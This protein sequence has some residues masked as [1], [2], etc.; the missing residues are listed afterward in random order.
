MERTARSLSWVALAAALIGLL[1][2]LVPTLDRIELEPG[3]PTAPAPGTARVATP[4]LGIAPTGSQALL[5]MLRIL[6]AAAVACLAFIIVGAF[7]NQKLRW[8]LISFVILCGLT[9]GI[10]HLLANRPPAEIQPPE[11][12]QAGSTVGA[13]PPTPVEEPL[14]E[15]SDAA[16][17]SVAIAVSMMVALAITVILARM[18][19]PRR[20]V[21]SP[22]SPLEELLDTL[23][24]ASEDIEFGGDPRSAV[25]RCYQEMLSI[26]CRQ[27]PLHHAHLT[28]RELADALHRSGF[29]AAHVD[30]LTEIFEL[31]RYGH[32]TGLPLAE[33]AAACLRAIREA[34]AT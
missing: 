10:Y 30:Q 2:V 7:F 19:R 4:D 3:E 9:I 17:T 28:A 33:R 21:P 23:A 26:L 20:R 8:Y 22:P 15:P 25:L 1:L 24:A 12:P 18:T 5:W 11:Q 13:S 16:F 34:Y 29:T 31:V 6:M 32:R 14:T 27:R